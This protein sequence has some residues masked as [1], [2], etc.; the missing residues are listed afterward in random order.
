M[1]R[2]AP[3]A[4]Q[5]LEDDRSTLQS[6]IG[7]AREKRPCD[8]H[9]YTLS[10][11]THK[12]TRCGGSTVMCF[13]HHVSRSTVT[14]TPTPERCQLLGGI[15]QVGRFYSLGTPF[16]HLPVADVFFPQ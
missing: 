6:R 13:K 3:L 2:E 14:A 9:N 8:S 7:L 5:T 12:L 4:G 16:T 1:N 10:I 11:H 15:V